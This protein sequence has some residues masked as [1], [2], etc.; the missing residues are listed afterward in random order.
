MRLFLFVPLILIYRSLFREKVTKKLFIE[1]R[2]NPNKIS[3]NS[4]GTAPSTSRNKKYQLLAKPQFTTPCLRSLRRGAPC[5]SAC[6]GKLTLVGATTG[7]HPKIYFILTPKPT[8]KRSDCS[9]F[10]FHYIYTLLKPLPMIS[11]LVVTTINAFSSISLIA[12]RSLI[13][14][15]RRQTV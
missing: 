12:A 14:S 9:S 7:C 4:Q 6:K 15:Y 1:L 10:N 3:A 8:K 11:L 13:A 5:A 2:G